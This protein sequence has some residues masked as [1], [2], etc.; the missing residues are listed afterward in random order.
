MMLLIVATHILNLLHMH[1]W[2]QPWLSPIDVNHE[3]VVA[4]SIVAGLGEPLDL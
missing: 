2:F 3:L 1:I 4:L